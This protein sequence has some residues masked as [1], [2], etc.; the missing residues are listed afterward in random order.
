MSLKFLKFQVTSQDINA[1]QP[2]ACNCPI[3]L[4]LKRH[5]GKTVGVVVGANSLW[6]D[7]REVILDGQMRDFIKAFDSGK[8]VSPQTFELSVIS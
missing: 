6:I 1:G 8:S 7:H 5:L 3:A 2:S 4:A